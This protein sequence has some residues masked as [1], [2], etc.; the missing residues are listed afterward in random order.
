MREER[1]LLSPARQRGIP[2]SNELVAEQKEGERKS[3]M[4]KR[5][6]KTV[7]RS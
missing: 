7:V 4:K 5:I 2:A 6:Q 1:S 3:K